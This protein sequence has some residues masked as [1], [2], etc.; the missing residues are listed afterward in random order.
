M[1]YLEEYHNGIRDGS[2]VVGLW[3]K[4][5]YE[6]IFKGLEKGL[7]YYDHKKALKAIMFM[8]SFV[9]HSEGRNDL[10]KLE[11]WQ[12]AIL[13]AI[14]G[15]VDKM[16]RRQFREVF[17]VI[18]RKNGKTLFASAIIAYCVYL[19]G[20]YGAKVYCLAPKLDQSDLVYSAFRNSVEMEPELDRITKSRKSDLYVASTMSS[21]KKL[22][23][24]HKKADGFNPHL[25]ICDEI[26]SWQGDQGLK[27]YE[28]MT[29]ALGARKQPLIVSISTAGYV[30]GSIYDELMARS[31][32][33]LKGGSN[34]T[35]LLPF[36][37]QIDDVNKW[38]D[39]I[40]LKKS[41]PNMGVSVTA[42]HLLE[43]AAI[44]ELSASKKRE[45][46]TKYCNIKQNSSQA[47]LDA[48]DIEKGFHEEA[49]KFEDFRNCYAV[50]GIDL[51]QTTDLTCATCVIEKDGKFNVFSQFWLPANRIDEAAARDEVPYRIYEQKGWLKASGDNYVDYHD[52]LKWVE[53]LVKQY[54][55]YPLVVGYDRY[56]AQYLVQELNMDGFKTDDV[57][58]GHNLTPVIRETEGLIKDGKFNFGNND[59]LKI[60]LLDTALKLEVENNKC[61]IVKVSRN[62]HIDGTAALLDAICVHQKWYDQ[63]GLQL[64]NEGR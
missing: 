61:K 59:L 55:I 44:A 49:L 12:K 17:I 30:D 4:L 8:E 24:N 19:D 57:F 34:E 47:W 21:V 39:I 3:I 46:M 52:C 1:T 25:T 18:A 62:A 26:A 54:K 33:L 48:I 6:M 41:N 10:L 40:E 9:H 60:H 63:Y 38:N 16:G 53:D 35:K 29:S 14:F 11:L 23:F 37:Y 22:A 45:F 56:T 28:V 15:I 58:Q 2:I 43:E 13:S 51:S 5:V 32:R 64:R 20:E 42:E 31:I 27:Q 50:V 36:I 7:F